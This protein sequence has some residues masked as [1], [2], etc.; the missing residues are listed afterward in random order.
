MLVTSSIEQ[1]DQEHRGSRSP[2]MFQRRHR[3]RTTAQP[4]PAQCVLLAP[5]QT[6]PFLLTLATNIGL[7]PDFP[8][9][10]FF[11]VRI[12]PKTGP[13]G[14]GKLVLTVHPL[15]TPAH[16]SARGGWAFP[17]RG[18]ELGD[19][20]WGACSFRPPTAW[21]V[22][23]TQLGLGPGPPPPATRPHGWRLSIS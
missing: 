8:N 13:R 6:L 15:S 4:T 22:R 16:R 9:F 21:A 23:G 12:Q 3:H 20:L 2:P 19:A 18:C 5:T 17:Q 1:C 7:A 14:A 11:L 10:S